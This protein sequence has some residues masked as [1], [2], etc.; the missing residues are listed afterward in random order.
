[1]TSFRHKQIIPLGGILHFEK[2]INANN[3]SISAQTAQ[4]RK[5]QE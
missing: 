3:Q 4:D 5:G 1:M 2:D